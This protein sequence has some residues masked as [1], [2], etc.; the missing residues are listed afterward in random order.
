MKH[1]QTQTSNREQING[2]SF[3]Q[4]QNGDHKAVICLAIKW[5]K[6]VQDQLM[7]SNVR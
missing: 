2:V 6:H 7:A 5:Y 3:K 1:L 4:L